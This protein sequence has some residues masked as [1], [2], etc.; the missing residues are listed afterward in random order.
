M[1]LQLMRVPCVSI[2]CVPQNRR[3]GGRADWQAKESMGTCE[4]M[5]N[6]HLAELLRDYLHNIAIGRRTMKLGHDE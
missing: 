4:V 3:M 1:V 5:H 6:T 2:L